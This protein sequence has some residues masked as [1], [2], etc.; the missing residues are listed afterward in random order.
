[1]CNT[2]AVDLSVF[3]VEVFLSHLFCILRVNVESSV[4]ASGTWSFSRLWLLV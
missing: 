1:M 2:E 3:C 4:I